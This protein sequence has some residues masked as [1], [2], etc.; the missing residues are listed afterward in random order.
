[1]QFV[2]DDVS[3]PRKRDAGGPV[4]QT[5]I[6]R[7]EYAESPRKHLAALRSLRESWRDYGL[8][9]VGGA[10]I[11]ADP[12]S[13]SASSCG[14]KINDSL[15]TTFTPNVAECHLCGGIVVG[16]LS[17]RDIDQG[18]ELFMDYGAPYWEARRRP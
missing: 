2:A 7:R 8:E 17:L 11:Y 4:M 5:L 6:S 1:M 3:G 12:G 18:E 14:H 9:L 13:F 10:T 15:G 16:M